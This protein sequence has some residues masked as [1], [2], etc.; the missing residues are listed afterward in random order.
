MLEFEASTRFALRDKR[1]LGPAVLNPDRS[2]VGP[3]AAEVGR[4]TSAA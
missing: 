1:H 2:H 4:P 3:D